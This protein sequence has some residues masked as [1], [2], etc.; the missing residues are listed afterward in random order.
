MSISNVGTGM[1]HHIQQAAP[2]K[3]K[4]PSSEEAAESPKQEAMEHGGK[5]DVQA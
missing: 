5:V 1:T 3:A 4:A 2:T